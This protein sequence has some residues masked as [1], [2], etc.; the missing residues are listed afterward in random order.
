MKLLVL[1]IESFY[2]GDYSLSKLTT[3]EYVRDSRFEVIGVSVQVDDG[4]PQWFSGTHAEIEA[5]L[6]LFD[7]ENSALVCHNTMFDAAILLWHFGIMPKRYLDTLSMARGWFGVD[8]PLSLGALS[9]AMGFG[10]KGDAVRVFKGV[11]RTQ[12]TTAEMHD[13]ADYCCN[14]VTLTYKIFQRF[15]ELG[16]PL[17]E[18]T[19]IDMTLRMFIEPTLVLDTAMLDSHLRDV[20][21]SKRDHLIN[22]LVAIGREDLAAIA[23]I[24][25]AENEQVKKE[26]RSNEQF[27]ELLRKLDVVPPTKISPTTGMDAYAFAKTDDG[28]KALLEHPDQRVQ[29]V[30]AARLG[31]KSTLEETRT[32]RFLNMSRRGALPIALLYAG[33]RT[34]RWSGT[35]NINL[36]NLPRKSKIKAALRAPDG[37]TIVGGDLSNI[38]LRVGLWLSG[39]MDKLR[40]LGEGRDLYKDFASSVF[41]TPYDEITT[42]QRFIG[43]TS[44][45]SLI[46]GVG[47][48]KLR[49]AIKQGTGIDIGEEESVRIV[50]LYR[51]EY[52]RVKLAWNKGE[53]ALRAINSNACIK[54]GAH[55]IITV[56]GRQGCLL[57]SGLSLQYPSLHQEPEGDRMVWYYQTRYGKEGIYGAKFFQGLVQ[58]LARCIIGEAMIRIGRQYH[59]A[60]TVH[61]A[62][63]LLV[64]NDEVEQAEQFTYTEL[65]RPPLWM[66]D[67]PLNA[68]MHSGAS[69]AEC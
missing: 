24:D 19:L 7:W 32:Q 20:K 3:E 44:Q 35:Q 33:A 1:D 27:A 51:E 54:Y 4:T 52:A 15:M 37:Y 25:S 2:D 12:F 55:E 49:A 21:D 45:L 36:Q 38:E 39:Q 31:M 53:G 61:D 41:G 65:C 9:P 17:S 56:R 69:L 34:K 62:V 48:A 58:S 63:Y 26:L 6:K 23:S 18:L 29:A 50:T 10:E 43:K 57:P 42:D 59:I 64:P 16:F 8:T 14:D 47:A 66:P 5:W 40:L 11:H 60:L 22:T 46:F 28:F 68:E 30:C 13:Y 67:I